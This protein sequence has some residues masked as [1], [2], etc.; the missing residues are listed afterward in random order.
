MVV[1]TTSIAVANSAAGT[2]RI[3]RSCVVT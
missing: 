3:A 1:F 2:E